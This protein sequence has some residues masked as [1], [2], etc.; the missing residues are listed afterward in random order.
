MANHY[1]TAPLLM[2]HGSFYFPLRAQTGT[3]LDALYP[4]TL[5]LMA[6]LHKAGGEV[7]GVKELA[8][9]TQMP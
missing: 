4:S 7:K 1:T 2:Q 3:F 6:A 8:S 9:S 5:Q